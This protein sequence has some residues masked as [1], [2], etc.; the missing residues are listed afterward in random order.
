MIYSQPPASWSSMEAKRV[1]AENAGPITVTAGPTTIHAIN[2]GDVLAKDLIIVSV[3]VKGVN[4]AVGG[5]CGID[6]TT[7]GTA[8][9]EWGQ[10]TANPWGPVFYSQASVAWRCSGIYVGRVTGAGSL[11]INVRGYSSGSNSSVGA[12]QSSST[13]RIMR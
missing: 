1:E 11:V 4:G 10:Y 7:A 8:T 13:T 5:M 12:N 3:D 9:I 2:M 6:L